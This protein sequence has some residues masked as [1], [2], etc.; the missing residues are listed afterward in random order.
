[1]TRQQFKHALTSAIPTIVCVVALALSFWVVSVTEARAHV[2][3][4]HFMN[5]L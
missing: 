2:P 4:L 1:M 3:Q 5:L